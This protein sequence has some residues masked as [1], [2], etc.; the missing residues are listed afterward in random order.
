MIG[1]VDSG[2]PTLMPSGST[3]EIMLQ[4]RT[5]AAITREPK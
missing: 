3:R 4:H 1:N 2:L 5:L